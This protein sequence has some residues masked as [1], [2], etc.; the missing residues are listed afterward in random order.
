MLAADVAVRA[1]ALGQ[2][3]AAEQ[4][5]DLVL[6]ADP[7]SHTARIARAVAADLAG[8]PRGI[9]ASMSGMPRPGRGTAPSEL[10][11]WLFAELLARRFD[12]AVARAWLDG[13]RADGPLQSADPA[14]DAADPLLIAVKRRVEKSMSKSRP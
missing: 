6:G 12:H 11:R 1:A 3:K 2:F 5:A 13:F 4:Q 7:S 8:D 9:R 14:Y 10:A